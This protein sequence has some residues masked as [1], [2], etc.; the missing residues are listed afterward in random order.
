MAEAGILSRPKWCKVRDLDLTA[1][2]R[3]AVA[4][5]EAMADEEH[6]AQRRRRVAKCKVHGLHYDP[7]LTSGCTLCRKEGLGAE[8]RQKPQTVLMLLSLLGVAVILFRM[9]GPGSAVRADSAATAPAATAAPAAPGA[10]SSR[11][12]PEPYRAAIAALEQALFKGS[13]ASLPEMSDQVYHGLAQLRRDLVERRE[14]EDAAVALDEI[15]ERIIDQGLSIESLARVREEWIRLRARTFRPAPWFVVPS[16]VAALTDRA[17]LM[18]YRAAADDLYALLGEG[19]ERARQLLTPSTPNFVDPKEVALNQETW[20][21]YRADWRRRI[22]ELRRQLPARP[23]ASADPQV[24]LAT[25]RLEQAFAQVSALAAGDLPAGERV[26]AAFD[27]AEQARR[28]FD[29]L[30]VP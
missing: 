5:A 28:S 15:G 27:A 24:L 7:R 1:T 22:V 8:P 11:L 14:G 20:R 2:V 25:Q 18:T 10:A 29:E 6:W 26:G 12:D 23:A 13:A 4:G 17:E 16:R 3:E 21:G 9:F 30:L 19:A